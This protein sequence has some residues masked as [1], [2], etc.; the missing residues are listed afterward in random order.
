M[1]AKHEVMAPVAGKVL[2][3]LHLGDD[4]EAG[5]PILTIGG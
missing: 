5:Q 2:G 3:R 4:V 1:K